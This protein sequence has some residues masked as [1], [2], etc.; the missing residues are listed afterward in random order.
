MHFDPHAEAFPGIAGATAGI[1][2]DNDKVIE[3]MR[4]KRADHASAIEAT[5]KRK[6][7]MQAMAQVGSRGNDKR[8]GAQ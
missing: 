2:S 5:R 8:A 4:E 3:V 6:V 7:H 1:H